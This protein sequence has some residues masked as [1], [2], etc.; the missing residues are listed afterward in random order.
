M[1]PAFF[2]V[3]LFIRLSLQISVFLND[4]RAFSNFPFIFAPF[5]ERFWRGFAGCFRMARD[6]SGR[7]R[8]LGFP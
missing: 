4:R 1:M 7:V 6:G 3:W 5:L 2:V 8:N